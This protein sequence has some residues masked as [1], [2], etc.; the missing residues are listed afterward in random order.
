MGKDNN[1]L[2][3]NRQ[4][5]QNCC[6][7]SLEERDFRRVVI[8]KKRPKRLSK[9]VIRGS[10]TRE[11]SRSEDVMSVVARSSGLAVIVNCR[12]NGFAA[13]N[14]PCAEER[15]RADSSGYLGAGKKAK[16]GKDNNWLSNGYR[17]FI[18]LC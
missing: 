15:P 6:C 11:R 10:P 12:T 2:S 13:T 7:K 9:M 14:L 5:L 8:A 3:A 18:G 4:N 1:W 17:K 16:M